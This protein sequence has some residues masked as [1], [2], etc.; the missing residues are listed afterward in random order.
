MK[1]K[2]SKPKK[3]KAKNAKRQVVKANLAQESV[4]PRS[5]AR[6]PIKQRPEPEWGSA[7]VRLRLALLLGLGLVGVWAYWPVLVQLVE[8]WQRE[9]DYSHGFL[10]VPLA[11]MFLYLRQ[12]TMPRPAY[13]LSLMGLLVIGLS[14]VIRWLG[15]RYFIDPIVGWSIPFWVAGICWLMLGPKVTWWAAPAIVFLFFMIPLPYALENMLSQPL[16]SASAKIATFALQCCYL[17]AIGEGNTILL[18]EHRL[19]VEKACSGMRIFF[20]IF[21]MAFALL[22]LIPR[23]W[24]VRILV[25]LAR[26]ADRGAGQRR[27]DIWNG[28]A[29]PMGIQGKFRW[30]DPR[31][32]RLGDDPGGGGDAVRLHVVRGQAVSVHGHAGAGRNRQALAGLRNKVAEPTRSHNTAA[33]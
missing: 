5:P 27:P 9:P 6:P 32:G 12:D 16:Q 3:R 1:T 24:F 10:V 21:A 17:P 2:Q 20:G 25:I 14:V 8:S 22:V 31:R 15:A 11:A 4:G 19:E 23:S 13:S 26:V 30:P 33:T 7:D 18:G 29:L 28:A